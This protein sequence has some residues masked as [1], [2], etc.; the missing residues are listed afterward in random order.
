MTLSNGALVGR[1]EVSS[2]RYTQTKARQ[3]NDLSVSETL[4]PVSYINKYILL[5]C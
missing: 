1:G 4:P 3:R 2:A 5:Q